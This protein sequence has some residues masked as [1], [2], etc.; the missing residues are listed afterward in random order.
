[1]KIQTNTAANSALRNMQ[2]N[3]KAT[4]Q[5]IQRLSS[6]FRINR[7]ADDAAGL[8]LANVLRADGKALSQA[9][10]NASQGSA[11]LQI[12]DGA[13]QTVSTIVDRMKE[14]ATQANSANVGNQAGK[15]DSEFQALVGE[16]GRIT[17]TTQYQGTNLIDGTFGATVDT[18]A[19]NSTLL[20]TGTDVIGAT[21]N[22]ATAGTYTFADDGAG[23]VSVTVGGVTQSL[24]AT[25]NTTLNFDK[26]GISLQIGAGYVAGASDASG[27]IVVAGSGSSS[28][29]VSS[30][31]HYSSTDKIS[32]NAV[33]MGTGAAGLNL[34]GLNLNTAG[35]AQTAL[36]RIDTAIGLVNTALGN[37]GAAESRF[38]FASNNVATTLQNVQAAE[39]TI[40]DADMA[41]EMTQFTKN[42]I[43]SQ[44]AQS[45]LSQANQ[46]TQGILQL[47]RG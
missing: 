12:M 37:I 46:G 23:N 40:R 31:G 1:M 7:A 20:A 45:M 4:E 3:S 16:I 44:A 15:L 25:A 9:Q 8:A 22:G 11:M 39:S 36:S 17:A 35:A 27:D 26:I 43:L 28:F 6:G 38:D 41:F 32:V 24:L 19:A 29:Q 47:L 5:S 2:V 13:T 10:K 33:N 14:L 34:T 30:S 42:N 18:N 21:L